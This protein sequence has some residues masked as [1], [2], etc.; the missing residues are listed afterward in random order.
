MN[1]KGTHARLRVPSFSLGA[2]V[3]G[4]SPVP[5]GADC[6]RSDSLLPPWRLFEG[7]TMDEIAN[8]TDVASD[9][10]APFPAEVLDDG[11][12][13][14]TVLALVGARAW[15]RLAARARDFRVEALV[16]PWWTV[17]Q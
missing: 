17:S 12:T 8:Q 5:R 10:L 6:L 1:F 15:A 13:D 2:R 11:L 7:V 16:R 9:L 14:A 3:L 4:A